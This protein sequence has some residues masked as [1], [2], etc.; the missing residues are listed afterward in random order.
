M[1]TL[2]AGTLV[3]TL[4]C[5]TATS[6]VFSDQVQTGNVDSFTQLDVVEVTDQT[7]G[8]STAVGNAY[9]V[10]QDTGDVDVRANQTLQGDVS[11]DMALNVAVN[12]GHSTILGTTAAGNTQDAGIYNGT[13]TGVFT[14]TTGPVAIT[15][16]SHIEAPN[17]ETADLSSSVQATGN[18]QGL[19]ASY[20][21]VGV[22]VN[23]TNEATVTTDGGGVYG[24]VYGTGTFAAATAANNVTSTGLGAAERM[25]INQRNAAGL[26]QV[27]QFTAFGQAS[28]VTTTSATVTGNN[29]SATND[30][31]PILDVTTNQTN[32]AYLRAQSETSADSFGR[33]SATAYGIGNT[34]LAGNVG[35][36]VVIDN[37]QL[38]EGG[39]VEVIASMT[40]GA[41][42]DAGSSASAIGNASTGYSCSDCGGNMT[43]SNRQTNTVDVA[44]TANTTVNYS[45]RS[46][47]AVS[48][49]VGNTA[50]YYVSRPQ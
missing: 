28:Y 1:K 6:Q 29:V 19:G 22:R 2:L 34:T 42:W 5:A 15:G 46:A 11:A 44:A 10:G 32:Q 23:Q 47:T 43:V 33:V 25:I 38:N 18:S 13:L 26:T 21:N 27:A 40:G 17:G 48:N 30:G 37:T 39:G 35:D 9:S 16:H 14:Q 49:A 3:A 12:S 50:N 45:G 8:A 7:L 20:A 31:G 4:T 36:E 24:A 41:G